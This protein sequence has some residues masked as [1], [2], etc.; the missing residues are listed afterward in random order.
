MVTNQLEPSS[1]SSFLDK[2]KLKLHF[3]ERGP[4]FTYDNVRSICRILGRVCPSENL[5]EQTSQGLESK[6]DESWPAN[7][8]RG[9]AGAVYNPRG[10]LSSAEPNHRKRPMD[11]SLSSAG[12]CGGTFRNISTNS[13]PTTMQNPAGFS[14]ASTT[15]TSGFISAGTH[16]RNITENKLNRAPVQPAGPPS[17]R[18]KA[19]SSAASNS[20]TQ[21]KGAKGRGAKGQVQGSST[22]ESA[23]KGG[24]VISSKPRATSSN[25]D[26]QQLPRE[27]ETIDSTF[28]QENQ[29]NKLQAHPS[30]PFTSSHFLRRIVPPTSTALG[31]ESKPNPYPFLSSSPQRL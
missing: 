25:R 13:V 22:T 27:V 4:S 30:Y 23:Q 15:M 8:G 12:P 19:G 20:T 9:R 10:Y 2:S 16:L 24:A 11:S 28:N 7:S 3:V 1:V 5:I 14:I 17:K 6:E 26:T 29:E 18:V 31:N 21:S